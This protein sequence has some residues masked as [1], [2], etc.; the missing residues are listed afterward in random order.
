[1]GMGT[2]PTSWNS[3]MAMDCLSEYLLPGA[4]RGTTVV[5]KALV[6]D[7][8]CKSSGSEARSMA[9][10][11]DKRSLYTEQEHPSETQRGKIEFWILIPLS[12]EQ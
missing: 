5:E 7:N 12:H 8:I 1:M 4:F 2:G 10:P 6:V 11:L 9:V 3:V